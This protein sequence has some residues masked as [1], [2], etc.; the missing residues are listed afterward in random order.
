MTVFLLARIST[1][2]RIE[3]PAP[4]CALN[5]VREVASLQVTTL[6]TLTGQYA[7]VPYVHEDAK[8]RNCR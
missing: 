8:D 2:L 6:D 7:S 5:W 4:G 1:C 3:A